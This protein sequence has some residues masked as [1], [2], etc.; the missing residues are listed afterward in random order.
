MS[1]LDEHAKAGLQ[2]IQEKRFDDAITSF[3]AAVALDETRPDIRHALAM[4]YLHRGDT[5]N[6]LEPLRMAVQLS[7]PFEAE[8]HQALKREFHLTLA[9]VQQLLDHVESAK[10]TL[11][12][13]LKR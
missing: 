3:T 4:A 11:Q 7:E 12:G 1:T 8:E 13:I 6:A 2:A 9:T 5:G 10:E